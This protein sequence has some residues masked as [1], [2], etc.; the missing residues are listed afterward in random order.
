MSPRKTRGGPGA[1]ANFRPS[2]TL[3]RNEAIKNQPL[4]L[5]LV[6]ECAKVESSREYWVR[7]SWTPPLAIL[8]YEPEKGQSLLESLQAFF[9]AL[10]NGASISSFAVELSAALHCER[11]SLS[12][13]TA[14]SIVPIDM[15]PA[16]AD[17]VAKLVFKRCY[18]LMGGSGT[19]NV[20]PPPE[21]EG[22]VLRLHVKISQKKND[23][24]KRTLLEIAAIDFPLAVPKTEIRGSV[25]VRTSKRRRKSR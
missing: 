2:L 7:N 8:R 15:M 4:D 14:Y 17:S 3:V 22:A 19:G 23:A 6:Y 16:S 10:F 21:M 9:K 25:R 20:S 11:Q 5:R 13:E 12:L 24:I 1:V 18:D